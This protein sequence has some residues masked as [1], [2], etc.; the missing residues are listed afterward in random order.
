MGR[1][2]QQ[3]SLDDGL[4]AGLATGWLGGWPQAG[5]ED[6]DLRLQDLRAVEGFGA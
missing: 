3:L 4:D 6:Q 5:L 2:P 1:L